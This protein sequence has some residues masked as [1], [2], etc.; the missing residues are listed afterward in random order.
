MYIENTAWFREVFAKELG[1]RA[2]GSKFEPLPEFADKPFD[3]RKRLYPLLLKYDPN[4]LIH[5]VFLESVAGVIRQARALSGFIEASPARAA[6]S[7]GVKFD[8]V[9]ASKEAGGEAK[10]GSGNVPY[11][12]D[13]F[14]PDEI[15]AYFNLDLA[16]LSGFGL[17]APAENMLAALSLFKIRCFLENWL[18]LRSMCDLELFDENQPV[19]KRPES[20]ALPSTLDLESALPD[21]IEAVA[22]KKLFAEPRVTEVTWPS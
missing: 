10:E 8:R 11:A 3:A 5:G 12:R 2:K 14:S 1:Y 15:V 22:Q 16:Q 6:A 20:F 18:R 17:G 13:E 7:G 4:C 21:L 19:V 9:R